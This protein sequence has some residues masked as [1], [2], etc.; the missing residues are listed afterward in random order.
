MI[1]KLATDP[2]HIVWRI[3]P[4]VGADQR[5]LQIDRP[6]VEYPGAGKLLHGCY[7]T[8]GEHTTEDDFFAQRIGLA[9]LA[10]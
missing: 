2:R 4:A 9:A 6:G 1:G 3:G 10:G 8:D 5:G 7:R